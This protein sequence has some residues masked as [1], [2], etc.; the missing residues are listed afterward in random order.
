MPRES[1]LTLALLALLLGAI[2]VTAVVAPPNTGDSLYYH[3]SRVAHWVQNR[4]VA[5][6]PT[7]VLAQLHQ[8]P[9]AEFI[10]LHLQVLSGGDRLANLVQWSFLCFNLVGV[11]LLAARLGASPAVQLWA[12]VFAATLPMGILQ[13]SSTKNEH[14]HTFWLLCFLYGL[15]RLREQVTW[16]DTLVTGAGLGLALLTKMTAYFYAFP[17]V[18]WFAV[19]TF[20]S[21]EAFRRRWVPALVISVL[22][23]SAAMPTASGNTPCGRCSPRPLSHRA[24]RTWT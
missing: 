11:S 14:V 4:S 15:L 5:H 19:D 18:L 9:G 23:P 20:R 24:W 6:Y 12:A 3:M 10:L 2:G 1:Q 21:R 22:A 16:R 13:A 8:N 17:F 7:H